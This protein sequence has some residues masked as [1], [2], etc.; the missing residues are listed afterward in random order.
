MAKENRMNNWGLLFW[1][2]LIETDFLK[3]MEMIRAIEFYIGEYEKT[4]PLSR[5]VKV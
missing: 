3:D 1:D 4:R 2:C 5:G